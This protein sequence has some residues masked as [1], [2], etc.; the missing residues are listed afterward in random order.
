MNYYPTPRSCQI[1]PLSKIFLYC[2]GKK[3]DGYFVDVGAYDGV[4]YSNTW[5][6]ASIGWGGLCVEPIEAYY[7]KCKENHA[8]HPDVKVL[9]QCIS[10]QEGNLDMLVAD[11]Y[12]TYHAFQPTT[13]LRSGLYKDAQRVSVSATTLDHAL[14]DNNVQ[15]GFEVLSVDVEGAELDVLAGFDINYW[16]PRMCIVEAHEW[17]LH[18]EMRAH[19]PDINAYFGKAHYWKIFSDDANNIYVRGPVLT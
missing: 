6:L 7:L 2:F 9:Q 16:Q 3:T 17:H 14:K 8:R 10:N 13:K 18:S 1:K 15:P 19:A 12:S 4:Q 11:V 5:G